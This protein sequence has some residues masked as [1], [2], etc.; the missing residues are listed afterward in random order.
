MLEHFVMIIKGTGYHFTP[1]TFTEYSI[2][3]RLLV[4]MEIETT[5][6]PKR[7]SDS[8]EVSRLLE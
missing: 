8:Q 4:E 2:D 5:P 6:I 7:L 1:N 3:L